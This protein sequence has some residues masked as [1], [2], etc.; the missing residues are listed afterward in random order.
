MRVEE[1]VDRPHI[2]PVRPVAVGRARHVVALHVIDGGLAAADEVRH[3][4]ATHVVVRGRQLAVGLH[5]LDE[6]LRVEDVVAHRGEHFAGAV[7][8]TLRVL[9]LLEEVAD[10]RGV[11]GVDVDDAE[12][13]GKGDR[14]ADAGDRRPRPGGDV[15]VQH[16]P[17]V[18]PIDVIGADDDDDVGLLVIDEVEA[19]QNGVGR[20]GEPP[21]AEALLR[22]DRCHI[23]VEERG[24][25]PRL[26]DVPVEAV[27][28]VL[29]EHDDLAEPRVD[30]IRDREVDQPVLSAERN[31]GLGAVRGQGHQA[32]ALAAGEDDSE[33]LRRSRHGTRV[34]PPAVLYY[35]RHMRV[36]IVTKE[37]PPEIYGGAGVHVAELVRALR[38][39]RTPE[40]LDLRVHAFGAPRDEAGVA[41]YGVPSGLTG[42]NGAIQTLGTDLEIVTDV[43]GADLVHSHTWYANFAGHLSAL[44]YDIPHV[45]TAHSLEPLR[46]WKAEQLGG[47]Y[48]VSSFLERTAYEGAAAIVAVSEGMRQTSCAATR[49]SIPRRSASSTTASTRMPGRRGRIRSSSAPGASTPRDPPSSSWAGSRVRRGCRTSCAPPSCFHAT[50]SSCSAPARPTPPRSSTRSRRSSAAFRRRGRV[51]SGSRSFCRARACRRS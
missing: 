22:G 3:D 8:E 2:A 36:D 10:A 13:V 33:D 40:Q 12:L 11:G 32:L 6:G 15:G 18:H 48:A 23:R 47:G 35:R 5:R 37:Y 42:A 29:R 25:P 28:L 9:R 4:V 21:L 49:C 26:G 17:E 45:L 34:L 27:R 24:H 7:E 16:L 51:S 43:S 50:C 41:S 20:P 30:E 46:P 38:E 1:G 31:G 39:G 14:L 44:L 19:L